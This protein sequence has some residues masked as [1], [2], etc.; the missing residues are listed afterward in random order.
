MALGRSQRPS[1]PAVYR[2]VTVFLG[3]R[4]NSWFGAEASLLRGSLEGGSLGEEAAPTP[5]PTWR[6]F[7][8][9]GEAAG[10]GGMGCE[11]EQGPVKILAMRVSESPIASRASHTQCTCTAEG[12]DC[13]CAGDCPS[14]AQIEVC[15]E[16]LGQCQCSHFDEGICECSGY[17]H[18]KAH[19]ADACF[20]EAGCTWSGSWCEAE[21]GLIWS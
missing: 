5:P 11:C 15:T 8:G 1:H 10:I 4:G 17:C 21:V 14:D 13:K 16:L 2:V 12:E 19:R 6:C 18:T 3:V 20:N 7:G 9:C